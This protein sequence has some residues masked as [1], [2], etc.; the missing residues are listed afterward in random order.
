MELS[1]FSDNP[2]GDDYGS[3]KAALAAAG[4]LGYQWSVRLRPGATALLIVPLALAAATG[5]VGVTRDEPPSSAAT[6]AARPGVV[7]AAG[8]VFADD[9][10]PFLALGTTLFWG[11]WGYEHDRDRLGRNLAAA[12]YAGF[13]YVRVLA[14]VGPDGWRDRTVDPR[15]AAWAGHVRAFTDW[16]YDGYGL[17]V[18]W[19]I[20]GGIDSTPTAASR[21]EAVARLADAIAGREHKVFAVEIANEG[22]QNGFS[23]ASG[24][25]ESKRLAARLR[26]TYR[27]LIATTAPPSIDCDAQTAWYA[28]SPASFVTL[29]LPRDGRQWAVLR[30]AGRRGHLSCEGVPSAYA[31]N[32]P[33]GPYSSG[34]DDR[35]PLRLAMA[36]AASWASGIGAYVLH[37]GPGIRGG[38][39]EDRRERRPANLWETEDW[40]AITAALACVRFTLPPDLP[41]WSPRRDGARDHPFETRAASGRRSPVA[42]HP[43]AVD[44]RRFVTLPMELSRLAELV[45]RRA[46][47]VR[48][49][50]PQTC[51]TLAHVRLA[52]GGVL[53]LGEDPRAVVIV[54]EWLESQARP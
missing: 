1:A 52:G 17:R 33:I 3:A 14:I 31:S 23:G 27:G 50:H 36:A 16:A 47:T 43:A 45:A 39:V 4:F 20:F 54:G 19:T 48:A 28:G 9:D 7:H 30:D 38:G 41:S 44:G 32:E 34:R 11:L 12:S 35:D 21:A 22:W 8:R 46:M 10:G 2:G 24:R 26:K 13:D 53:R 5:V 15:E 18:Q 40:G 6:I 42:H 25:Q 37:T 51:S 49:V 29:H